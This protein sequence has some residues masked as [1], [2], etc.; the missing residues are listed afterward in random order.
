MWILPDFLEST[1]G[2]AT[3]L[4]TEKERKLAV[5]RIIEDRV[6]RSTEEAIT[7]GLKLAVTH[8]RTWIFVS[9]CGSSFE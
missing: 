9:G 3:W 4:S 5:D 7:R 6:A 8:Y 2:I 1:T